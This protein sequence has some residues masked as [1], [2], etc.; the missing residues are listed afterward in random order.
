MDVDTA[1]LAVLET[2]ANLND[3]VTRALESLAL[4]ADKYDAQITGLR[5]EVT[6]LRRE[7]DELHSRVSVVERN[8]MVERRQRRL[9]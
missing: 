2:Q 3:T 1:I 6:L 5:D 4:Q 8:A 9:G 7:L